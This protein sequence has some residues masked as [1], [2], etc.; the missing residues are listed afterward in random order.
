[1]PGSGML[2]APNRKRSSR[3]SPSTDLED[4]SIRN[5]QNSHFAIHEV[6]TSVPSALNDCY[7]PVAA[8]PAGR[9]IVQMQT[10]NNY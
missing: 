10:S 2:D 4:G 3:V 5:V 9:S 1:M 8:V 7:R 6:G